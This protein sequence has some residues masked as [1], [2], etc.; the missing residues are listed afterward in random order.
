[1]A[2]YD[3]NFASKLAEVANQVDENDPWAYD[4]RR[5]TIYISR[6]SMEL[7]LKA[8]LEKAGFPIN[9]IRTRS[10]NLRELLKDLG[11]CEVEVHVTNNVK[12]WVPATRVRAI[13]IDLGFVQI[14]I[15]TIIDAENQGTSCYPNEIRYGERIV[16]FE[17]SFVSSTA[18][19]LANWAKQHWELIRHPA[20]Q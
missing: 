11:E 10:H 2:E 3:L 14:P 5:V 12:A 8:L 18:V 13:T 9:R 16:D 1:M 7:T 15:G 19:L 20:K 17:P 4:A 6:L